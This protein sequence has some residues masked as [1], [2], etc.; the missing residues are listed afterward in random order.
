MNGRSTSKVNGETIS[1]AQLHQITELLLDIYGQHE[2]QSLLYRS[3]HLEILD[4]FA[5]K[6]LLLKKQNLIEVFEEYK[7]SFNTLKY[8]SFIWTS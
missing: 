2:H 7:K 8:L 4:E 1:A 3:K 5:G 6:E